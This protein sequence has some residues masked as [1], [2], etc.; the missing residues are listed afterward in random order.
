MFN[1]QLKFRRIR[2]V[3]RSFVFRSFSAGVSK[4]FQF[5]DGKVVGAKYRQEEKKKKKEIKRRKGKKNPLKKKETMSKNV[6][7]SLLFEHARRKEKKEED[8][9]FSFKTRD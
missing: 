6:T 4:Q 9:T 1:C 7:F 3:V 2:S 8:Y 5:L